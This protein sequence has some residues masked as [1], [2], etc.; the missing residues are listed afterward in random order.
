M[1][2][3]GSGVLG[4]VVGEE[5][6]MP[7]DG[8]R[9]ETKGWMERKRDRR[10]DGEGESVLSLLTVTGDQLTLSNL[11]TVCVSLFLDCVRV[12]FFILKVPIK[13]Q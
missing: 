7:L 2:E 5:G 4:Q 3:R 6:R 12:Y 10:V 13:A 11:C 8:W 1:G 9:E